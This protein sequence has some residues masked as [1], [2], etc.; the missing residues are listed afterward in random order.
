MPIYD[1]LTNEIISNPNLEKGKVYFETHIIS[2][3]DE[4]IRVMEGTIT[5]E[6]PEGLKEYIPARDITEQIQKYHAY[7]P[8]E[9]VT[10]QQEKINSSQKTYLTDD[11][12]IRLLLNS[13]QTEPYPYKMPQPGYQWTMKFDKE[14][15][16]I[17]EETY[18][19]ECYGTQQ[20]PLYWK[21]KMVIYKDYYYSYKDVVKK[22]V[23]ESNPESFDDESFELLS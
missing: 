16:F 2:H 6:T 1:E 5:P 23:K 3:E 15:G 4:V 19:S 21:P 22:C 14:K 20:K 12:K 18:N 17:W 9:L 11:E 8:E 7:T 13:I 10:Q